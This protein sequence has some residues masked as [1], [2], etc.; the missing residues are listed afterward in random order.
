VDREQW[1]ERYAERTT[2]SGEPNAALVAYAPPPPRPAATA[3]DLGCGEGA[4]ALWLA[5]QGWSVI[6][7]DWAGVALERA[8][9]AAEEP[10]LDLTFTEA[11]I[12]DAAVL[13]G[14][15]SSGTFDLVTLA[16]LHPEPE[17]RERLYSPLASLVA[18]GGDLLVIAH[19]PDQDALGVPGP[20]AHRLLSATDLVTALR[21]PEDFE[22]VIAI[23]RART[24]PEEQP[25]GPVIVGVDAVLLA[26][27]C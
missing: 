14:L 24:S 1:N 17:E 19:A 21:L 27:R 22:I 12:T 4:D 16:F 11:D 3:L 26:H 10:G 25:E 15:S 23:T 18:P 20:P 7:V 6:G 13:A 9:A 2:W 8:R 5:R